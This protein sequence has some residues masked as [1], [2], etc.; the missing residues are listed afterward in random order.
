MHVHFD[1]RQMSQKNQKILNARSS[2][3]FGF[4]LEAE[5]DNGRQSY[6][7]V[8]T[9]QVRYGRNCQVMRVKDG[10]EPNSSEY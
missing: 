7:A 6:P 9:V 4:Y 3:L 2:T 8:E 1:F 5:Q 10:L